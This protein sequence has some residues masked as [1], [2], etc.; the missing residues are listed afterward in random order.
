MATRNRHYTFTLNNYT[1]ENETFLSTLDVHYIVFGYE[2][3]P[4][5][6]TPHLQ[7]FCTFHSAKSFAAAKKFFGIKEMH[8]EPA[9]SPAKAAA[10]CKKDGVFFESGDP[11]NDRSA[12]G[13]RGIERWDNIRRL[14]SVGDFDAIPS[15]VFVRYPRNI[16][17]V[18]ALSLNAQCPPERE[19]LENYWLHGSTGT[20]K[21][22]S[23]RDFAR[24][25]SLGLYLKEGNKWWDGY[26]GEPVVLLEEFGP[27][28]VALLGGLLKVW[29]D[30]YPFRC[31]IKGGSLQIRPRIIIVTSN[32]SMETVF[33]MNGVLEPMIRRFTR[34]DFDNGDAFD[35]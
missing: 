21:S 4:D 6:G 20:G 16:Q 25:H 22:R 28:H 19:H 12:S 23:V 24:R 15:D 18:R 10:Y 5:T 17:L 32:F 13:E 27:E 30:H 31:E 34:L 9:R 11:P 29:A 3:A 35:I 1:D 8:L 7:G 2:F 33:S 26:N 14:A